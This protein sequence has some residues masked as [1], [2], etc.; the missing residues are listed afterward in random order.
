MRT[1]ADAHDSSAAKDTE[2]LRLKA[3]HAE[4]LET[5]RRQLAL[6]HQTELN[7]MRTTHGNQMLQLQQQ[8]ARV[9]EQL[10]SARTTP[11]VEADGMHR[12]S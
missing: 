6:T 1:L 11:R 12:G 3:Y 10:A 2:L 8:H 5:L 4:E 9:S 7:A